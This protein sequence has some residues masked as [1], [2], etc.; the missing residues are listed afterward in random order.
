MLPTDVLEPFEAR[1]RTRLVSGPGTLGRLGELVRA[2][3]IRRVLLVTDAGLVSAGHVARAEALLAEAGCESARHVAAH[4]D[5][6]EDDVEAARAVAADFGPEGFL[7][8]GG[9][10]AIDLAKGAAM[11]LANGGR[12]RDYWG[13]ARTTVPLLP[14]VAVP[15]TAGTGSEVQ[16]FALVSHA[17]SGRKMACGAA[18]GAPRVALLDPELT[19]TLPRTVTAITGFD[20]LGHAL[21][22]AVTR[23]ATTFSR[24]FAFAAWE[25]AA[26][27]LPRVL[28]AGDDLEARAA[29]QLA[30]SLAGLAIE[31]SMLGAAHAM[32][33]PATERFGVP[34]GV[35]V[36][37]ALPH[38][39][40]FNAEDPGPRAIYAEL[41]RRVR[42]AAPGSGDEAAVEALIEGLFER[43][44]HAGISS[45]LR[46]HGPGKD[47]A[48]LLAA[49]AVQQWT[50]GYNPR[51]VDV[52]AFEALY[53]AALAG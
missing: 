29:M 19:L 7:G 33:N 50:G 24:A 3:G 27:A 1:V 30:A 17:D 41:A 51:P 47:D 32:A 34:H 44:A 40:R 8:L 42:W 18:D 28:D 20:A 9:G 6:G 53:R 37:V 31:N 15:T 22:T 16:S 11:L 39:V 13:R 38:V 4:G 23:A 48:A 49:G 14:I 26:P 2:L 45:A 36:A 10:S 52:A 12:M 43:L 21:E 25:R 5:P 35:A 46:D